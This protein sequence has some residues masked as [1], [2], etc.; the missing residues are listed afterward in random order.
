MQKLLGCTLAALLLASGAAL[1]D[2][3]ADFH[4]ALKAAQEARK[5]AQSVD[6]EWRDI[7]KILKHAKKAAKKG[8]FKKAIGLAHFAEFQGKMGYS[9][10]MS[11]KGIGNPDYFYN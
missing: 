6:G 7:G 11:Q 10:A 5:M 9:Q 1:A 4:K 8:H 2:A 3:K